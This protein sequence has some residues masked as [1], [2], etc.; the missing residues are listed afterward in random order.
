[1]KK[2]A[3]CK[4]CKECFTPDDYKFNNIVTIKFANKQNTFHYTCSIKLGKNKIKNLMV[5]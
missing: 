5:K 1:M 2:E 4:I 3:R